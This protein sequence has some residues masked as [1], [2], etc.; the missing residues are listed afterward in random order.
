MHYRSSP[1]NGFQLAHQRMCG[2]HFVIAIGTDQHQTFHVRMR[3]QIL[4]Q[5]QRS[6]VKPLQIVE[7]ER[8]GMLPREHANKATEYQLE[9]TLRISWWKFRDRLLLADDEL[10]F[11]D[12]IHHELTVRTER[13]LDCIA[14]AAHLFFVLRQDWTDEGLEGLRE[15]RIRYVAFVLVEFA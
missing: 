12:Q 13:L 1:A 3:E 11:G 7:E 9:A 15:G 5:I 8:Y 6:R 4:H 2:G 14:P 10:Q